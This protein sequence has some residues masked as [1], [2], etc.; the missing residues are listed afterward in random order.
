M[1]GKLRSQD[2]LAELPPGYQPDDPREKR[3]SNEL[4]RRRELVHRNEDNLARYLGHPEAQ[5][6]FRR[7]LEIR[8]AL[9]LP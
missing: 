6:R 9:G 7:F 4:D 3:I 5:Q 1:L 2:Q 8:A